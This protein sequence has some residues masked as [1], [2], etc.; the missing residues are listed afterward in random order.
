MIM[1]Q[2]IKSFKYMTKIIEK[3]KS[4]SST[5]TSPSWST[6]MA[7]RIPLNTKVTIRMK[8]LG[9]FWR[10]FDLP[11]INCEVELNWFWTKYCVF[12]EDEANLNDATFQINSTKPYVP[13]VTLSTN[14][15]IKSLRTLQQEFERTIF[16]KKYRS[17]ITIHRQHDNFNF[18]INPTFKTVNRLFVFS[19]KNSEKDSTKNYFL[20]Y[21]MLLLEIKDFNAFIENKPF[22]IYLW[23]TKKMHMKNLWK[24]LERMIIQQET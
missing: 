10:P 12:S 18:T 20:K 14:D 23:Q 11:L 7:S 19:F 9:N 22:L 3:S 24:C 5:T 15:N 16:W 21:Y 2:T 13:V 17:E 6:T 1:L 4:K 8:Y